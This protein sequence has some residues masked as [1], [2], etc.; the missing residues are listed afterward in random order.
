MAITALPASAA[1]QGPGDGP[2][3]ATETVTVTARKQYENL[4][5]VPATVSVITG[6]DIE[7]F[8]HDKPEDVVALVPALTVQ[9]G[10][11]GSGGQ[12]T[13]RG[14]GSS[15]TSAAFDSAVAMDFDGVQ[16]SAMRILQF[17][18]LDMR[19]IEVLKGPQSLYFGKSASA[20]VL[21]FKSADPTGTREFGGR[22][23]YEVEERGYT[24][25]AYASGPVTGTLGFRLAAQFNDV[26]RL[27]RNSAPGVARPVRGER[28]AN[29]RA[30][31]QLDPSDR[32][33]ANPKL[34]HV[35]Y[36]NDGA[37]RYIV[38]DCGPNGVADP[39]V[40]FD[41][42]TIP[43]GYGCDTSGKTYYTNRIDL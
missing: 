15:S 35:R 40:L 17:G 27:Y 36:E 31:F 12:I 2:S 19:Q 41:G 10:G 3:R 26:D 21:S 23:A 34:N 20:G 39:L 9:V 1:A 18:F 43:A 32:F 16:I 11:P 30:T 4:Q 22:A 13:L 29:L 5:D 25:S 28:N 8:R 37:L 33:S 42:R 24:L 6:H 38:Q 14:I 7:R